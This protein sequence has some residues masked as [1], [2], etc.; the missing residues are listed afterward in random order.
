MTI[1]DA[2]NMGKS[3][4]I[5]SYYGIKNISGVADI[6]CVPY[7]S[8]LNSEIRNKLGINLNNSIIVFDE[9]HNII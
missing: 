8:I 9:A 6:L 1:E 2:K 4:N 7:I 3:H 5:C